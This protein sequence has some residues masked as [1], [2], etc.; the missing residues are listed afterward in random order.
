MDDTEPA[1]SE[2]RPH[3]H[4]QTSSPPQAPPPNPPQ[5]LPSTHHT[6]PPHPHTSPP[7]HPP[8]HSDPNTAEP[9]HQQSYLQHQFLYPIYPPL[10]GLRLH[11]H[12]IERLIDHH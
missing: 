5:Q 12:R 2:N 1:L 9:W 8:H 10:Y 4:D 11:H 3:P 6:P 7:K